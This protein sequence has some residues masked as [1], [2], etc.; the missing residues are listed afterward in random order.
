M[1]DIALISGLIGA[2]IT[3]GLSY[4]IRATLD[5]KNL[6]ESEARLAYVHF[7]RVSGLVA[8][9]LVASSFLKIYAGERIQKELGSKDG[10]FEPS[11]KLSVIF[12]QEIKKLTPETFRSMPGLSIVP[13][14][15]KF[16]LEAI[17]ES[18]LSA[19][20]LAK[21]PKEIVFSYSLF[22][23]YLSHLRGVVLIWIDFFETQQTSALTPENIHDQ[24]V[25]VTRFFSQARKLR[26]ELL[27]AGAATQSESSDLLR[28][29]VSAYN[30][31]IVEK[32]QHQPKLQ[33]AM[34][35]ANKAA[36][37]TD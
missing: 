20:Q 3:A 12:A 8:I 34:A 21:L 6:K 26:S 13:A 19:E 33:A 29:Q 7:V 25:A 17:T 16:Q 36:A 30:E 15:L 37:K 22:L 27:L 31:Q 18:Q 1:R 24:W 11:H 9:E 35:E 10:A 32:F 23:T 5:R 4:W 28:K 2:L 14:F